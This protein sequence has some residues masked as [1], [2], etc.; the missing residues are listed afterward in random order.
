MVGIL[1]P[2]QC[3]KTTLARDYVAA[4]SEP[5]VHYFDLEDP[6]H[7]NRLADP[8]LALEPLEGLIVIDEIQRS[9][10]LFPLLRVL[11]DRKPPGQRYLI[12]GSASRELIRQSSETLAGRIAYL[13]LPPFTAFEAEDLPRL[14]LRGGFPPAYL[15]RSDDDG[16]VWRKAY[17]TTFLER[18]VPALG[19][20]FAANTMRRF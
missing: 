19:I 9:P 20:D 11:I 7:L 13:E 14:W 4:R 15:A 5:R 17:V 1:G 12:L 6:E 2:R 10:E 18:D 3:G 8:K 16:M